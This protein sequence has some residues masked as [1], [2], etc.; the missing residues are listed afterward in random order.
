MFIV[1]NTILETSISKTLNLPSQGLALD[2]THKKKI[3][4]RTEY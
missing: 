2:H 4:D 3:C 1:N